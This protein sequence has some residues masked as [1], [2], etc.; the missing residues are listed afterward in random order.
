MREVQGQVVSSASSDFWPSQTRGE[1]LGKIWK[2]SL[3]VPLWSAVIL[4]RTIPMVLPIDEWHQYS[5]F[6][7]PGPFLMQGCLSEEC[8]RVPVASHC[9]PI[10]L[11]FALYFGCQ[12]YLNVLEFKSMKLSLDLGFSWVVIC[13]QSTQTRERSSLPRLLSNCSHLDVMSGLN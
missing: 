5:Y 11:V 9:L 7:M 10:A 1:P 8:C 12:G 13:K 2:S 3:P 6:W 4:D